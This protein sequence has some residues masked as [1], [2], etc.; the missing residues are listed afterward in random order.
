MKIP[1]VDIQFLWTSVTQGRW[2]QQALEEELERRS[3]FRTTLRLLWHE[4]KASLLHYGWQFYHTNFSGLPNRIRRQK[5][6][7]DPNFKPYAMTL[8]P[9]KPG[10]VRVL[11]AIPT[12]GTGGSQQLIV[13]II[14][15]TSEEYEHR[16]LTHNDWGWQSYTGVPV[17][18]LPYVRSVNQIRQVL[19]EFKPDILHVHYWGQ[20]DSG[21]AHWQW[22]H[23]VFQA[24]FEFG[25]QV[26]ENCNNPL[27][28]YL[29]EKIAAYVYVSEYAQNYFG[30][31]S[32]RNNVIYPGS[33]FSLFTRSLT[34][35]LP[36]DTIGMVYRLDQDKLNAAAI[37]VFI[38]VVQQRPQTQ[39]IIVGSGYFQEY[40][41]QRVAEAGLGSSFEFTGMVSYR[42]LPAQYQ[43][44]SLFV[45]PVHKESFGQV[46]P[47]A[48]N[49]R[50]PVV[51]YAIGALPEILVNEEVLAPAGDS[52]ALAARIVALL[53]NPAEL[54]RLGNFNR[55]RAQEKFGLA[56]MVSGYSNLYNQLLR[57]K[58]AGFASLTAG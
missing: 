15:G 8:P 52:D 12:F 13:D 6:L 47:F 57:E 26:V 25:C 18:E 5:L 39:V 43:R 34:E 54:Q 1:P 19:K 16:L 33:N 58:A 27:V 11:H 7:K 28:P 22:Y 17:Q 35:P 44:F 21:H 4:G 29:H 46:T 32:S 51:S 56:A 36:T 31:P 45:A 49:M 30:V 48:M 23:W 40:Y 41:Q 37:E 2:R 10:R 50:L 55:Q 3:G 20:R 14:E 42:D 24:G 38:K 9:P 53:N